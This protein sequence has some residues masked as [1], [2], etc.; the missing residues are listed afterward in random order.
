MDVG[1]HDILDTALTGKGLGLTF[2]QNEVGLRMI[3]YFTAAIVL[4]EM[5]HNHFF[6]HPQDVNWNRGSDYASS[7]P[8]VAALAGTQSFA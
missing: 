7:L 8:H 6:R 4:H 1:F 3:T 2:S 5:M